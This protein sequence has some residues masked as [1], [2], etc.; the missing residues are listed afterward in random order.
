M[1]SG[2]SISKMGEPGELSD[3]MA[4]SREVK[5]AE[6]IDSCVGLFGMD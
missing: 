2:H 5:L 1:T 6:K 3:G 4:F